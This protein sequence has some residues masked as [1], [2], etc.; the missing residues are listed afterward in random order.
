MAS[1]TVSKD[2]ITQLLALQTQQMALMQAILT[3]TSVAAPA[4]PASVAGSKKSGKGSRGPRGSSGWD[5]FKKQVRK[6]MTAAAPGV[7]FSLKEVLDECNKR[8]AA[9]PT[10]YDEAYW[11][12]QAA[13]LKAA[14][15]SAAESD[16]ESDA[17]AS[18]ASKGRGRPKGSKNKPKAAAAPPPPPPAA[19]DEE[20]EE[21]EVS[22]WTWK[23]KSYFKT[24]DNEVFAN[25]DGTPGD[26]LGRY[27]PATD[28]IE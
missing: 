8:K 4:A 24:D 28:R 25:V 17:P 15:A 26:S 20:D 9:T 11:K 19:N 7:K 27:N 16:S 3:G 2:V 13:A 10:Q 5:L 18:T 21:A 1:F 14:G 12:A 6:E 22:E 23:G